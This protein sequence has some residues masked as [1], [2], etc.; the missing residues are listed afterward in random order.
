[1]DFIPQL[2]PLS[3]NFRALELQVSGT[4]LQLVNKVRASNLNLGLF[5]ATSTTGACVALPRTSTAS[6][7]IT[8]SSHHICHRTGLKC[9]H[10]VLQLTSMVSQP[11]HTTCAHEFFDLGI[12][13]KPHHSVTKHRLSVDIVRHTEV[14]YGPRPLFSFN[15]EDLFC[16]IIYYNALGFVTRREPKSISHTSASE[17]CVPRIL[18]RPEHPVPKA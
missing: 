8:C 5:L 13:K 18:C 16:Y 9:V 14:I 10:S 7:L 2:L 12:L 1:M 4:P 15:P 17:F 6:W 3:W 11:H